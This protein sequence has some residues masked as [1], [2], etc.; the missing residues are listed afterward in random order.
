[1]RDGYQG[2][3]GVVRSGA[4]PH[5]RLTLK[6]AIPDREILAAVGF[7][8]STLRTVI[9]SRAASCISDVHWACGKTCVDY[10]LRRL[11]QR[12]PCTWSLPIEISADQVIRALRC[13]RI[14]DLDHDDVRIAAIVLR[15]DAINPAISSV[16]EMEP[17]VALL[18]GRANEI[19]FHVL[20]GQPLAARR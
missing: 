13:A 1:M 10:V 12:D 8:E 15:L 6:R 7:N 18:K 3:I 11:K 2:A 17:R 9:A 14:I 19:P 20:L 4:P 16:L 5:D